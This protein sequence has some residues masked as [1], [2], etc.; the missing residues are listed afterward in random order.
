MAYAVLLQYVGE[1]IG[2]TE[3]A[4]AIEKLEEYALDSDRDFC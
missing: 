1:V 3:Y 4:H 2:H